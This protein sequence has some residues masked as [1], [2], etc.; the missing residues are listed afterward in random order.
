MY[1]PF[2]FHPPDGDD[3]VW[4]VDATRDPD[5][6]AGVDPA[7]CYGAAWAAAQLP[8][9]LPQPWCSHCR[10]TVDPAGMLVWIDPA[11][12]ATLLDAGCAW[13]L[14]FYLPCP[15]GVRRQGT[16]SARQVAVAVA[17]LCLRTG[18]ALPATPLEAAP[19]GARLAPGVLRPTGCP[20]LH[21]RFAGQL[22]LDPLRTRLACTLA[23]RLV[24]V[25]TGAAE[26]L[27]HAPFLAGVWQPGAG[28]GA[29][30]VLPAV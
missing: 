10:T 22:H 30:Q 11:D 14:A 5:G 20:G 7:A 18:C 25:P 12:P 8:A 1:A 19:D 29:W 23:V 4:I 3:P 26:G 13:E 9:P 27:P 17:D 2:R 16:L 6:R 28:W 21:L 15:A 24:V